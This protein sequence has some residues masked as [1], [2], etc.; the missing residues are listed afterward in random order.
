MLSLIFF[1][2]RGAH[3]LSDSVGAHEDE[4]RYLA[5]LYPADE[6]YIMASGKE[7]VPERGEA[8]S[9]QYFSQ[10]AESVYVSISITDMF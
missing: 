2:F 7:W 4:G 8:N 1:L 5:I 3:A 9:L 6:E 10:S